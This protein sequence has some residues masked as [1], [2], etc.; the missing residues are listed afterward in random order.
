MGAVSL[1]DIRRQLALG[2]RWAPLD[3]ALPRAFCFQGTAPCKSP[4][5]RHLLTR[6]QAGQLTASP[7]H[8]VRAERAG[9]PQAL[10]FMLKE[11]ICGAAGVRTA[12]FCDRTLIFL[13]GD[14]PS[15][16]QSGLFGWSCAFSRQEGRRR[17]QVLPIKSGPWLQGLVEE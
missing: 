11:K 3:T 4:P 13:W 10:G 6:E 1:V 14:T 9:R 12:P 7:S 2:D 8:C 15:S 5:C 17:T 16:F